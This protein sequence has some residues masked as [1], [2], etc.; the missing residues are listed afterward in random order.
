MTDLRSRFISVD[1][2]YAEGSVETFEQHIDVADITH[3]ELRITALGVYAA[4]I[5]GARVGD[6]ILTPGFTYYP[7]DLH[8][9][10]YDVTQMLSGKSTLCVHLAQGWYCGRFG[11]ENKTRIY[12]EQ[13]AVSWVL[14]VQTPNGIRM[15]CSDDADVRAVRSPYV[16]ASL[17]D[18]EVYRADG[19]DTEVIQPTR[20]S[21][22]IP[23]IIEESHMCVR[24]REEMS[25]VSATKLGDVTILDFGQN[26][27]GI[28][29]IDPS[30][31]DGESLLLRHGEVL[32][33]DGSLYTY[34]LRQ[35][36]AQTSYTR[37]A[38]M[39]PYRPAFT[40]MGFRYV[41]L[42]G[43]S[44]VPGLVKAY[45]VYSDM[46]RTGHFSCGNELVDK[47]YRNQV[48][49]QRSNYVEV[50]TDC[51]QRDER[52]GY[53]GDGHVFAQTGAYNYDT[54]AF[55]DKFLKDIR[56][57]QL[58]SPEGYVTPTVPAEPHEKRRAI[59]MLGWGNCVCIVPEKLYWQFGDIEVIRKQYESMR[60]FVECEI[61]HMGWR[62][63]WLGVS[64]GD[65][66]APGNDLLYMIVHNNPVSNAFIV[67]DLRIMT[68]AARLLG[69]QGDVERYGNQL[70]RTRA[71]YI[72]TF[73]RRDGRMRDDYQ[74][75]YV[76]AL[77]MVISHGVLW[78][79]VFGVLVEKLRSEGLRTGFFAS[80]HLLPLLAENG[81]E[82]LA[83]DLL[84]SEECP[85]WLYQVKAG[86]TTTWER[87]D[88]L[89]PD[90]TVNA[91]D[92]GA[93]NMVS[94]NHYAFGSV[95]AFLYQQVLGIKPAE[96][97]FAKVLI[98]PYVDERLGKVRGSYRSVSG[99]I[100][101]EVD[102]GK[103]TITVCA[104]MGGEICL[105]D[106]TTSTLPE[107]AG[108]LTFCYG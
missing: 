1:R 59:N 15:F 88:S 103:R 27:A 16:S 38:D 30:K 11:F 56:Y 35:A 101:V 12:G 55:W 24:P 96:P 68:W 31:M 49:G 104:P 102:P 67:N 32:N 85:S 76:M 74:G 61:R 97:G 42:S 95:A 66:L 9:Q 106:G 81:Q 65:W 71:A 100:C 79:Q 20:F 25:V 77:K 2:P 80:E 33:D 50:P 19:A 57:S 14:A 22:P 13:P 47:L 26:F 5:D 63:L 53:T 78:D 44:Y 18:G 29:E 84:L 41:E 39:R 92:D 45:A 54:R 37:G 10:R 7:L 75:A 86:A 48:W 62:D 91:S 3:A 83:F 52:M 60:A 93:F 8:Y 64:L 43:V 28:V 73:I 46:E 87:W 6:A 90:G 105:P 99:E 70:E 107:G 58:E 98:Q 40:Y 21:G 108:E 51:P 94:F 89:R 72:R 23:R 17:Y 36:K 82:Q 34:N 69:K 4:E